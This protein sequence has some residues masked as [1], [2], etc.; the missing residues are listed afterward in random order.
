M[1]QYFTSFRGNPLL[2]AAAWLEQ[3]NACHLREL[4]LPWVSDNLI[5]LEATE[6]LAQPCDTAC[7]AEHS[8]TAWA[9]ASP[10]FLHWLCSAG[11]LSCD[12]MG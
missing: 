5:E 3:P 8:D 7:L 10:V 11:R 4:L 9:R 2:Q 1:A 6:C 12:E